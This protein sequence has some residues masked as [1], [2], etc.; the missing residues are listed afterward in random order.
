M[1]ADT[2][3]GMQGFWL[4]LSG[5]EVVRVGAGRRPFDRVET[6]SGTRSE[7]RSNVTAI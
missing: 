6:P 1:A 7:A 3:R 4:V 5:V 2:E